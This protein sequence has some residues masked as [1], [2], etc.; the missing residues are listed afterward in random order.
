MVRPGSF[1]KPG[2]RAGPDL[3]FLGVGMAAHKT[4][5]TPQVTGPV[6]ELSEW[7]AKIRDAI[8]TNK[9]LEQ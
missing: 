1:A 4:N 3:R 2:P 7:H 6:M 8:T 9:A 5:L